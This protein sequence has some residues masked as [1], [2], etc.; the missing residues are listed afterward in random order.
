MGVVYEAVQISLGRRVALKV[1]PFAAT[2]DPKQLQRFRNEAQAAA[3]LQHPHIVPVHYVGCERGVHF[4]AMQFID[5]QT[6]AA[7]IHELRRLDRQEATSP[8]AS[9]GA[10]EPQPTTDYVPVPA[11]PPASRVEPA[12]PPVGALS[13]EHSSRSP[14]FFRT[15]ANLGVQAAEALEHAHQLGVIHRDIKPANLLV[16]TT[17]PLAPSGARGGGEGGRLWVTDFGLAH[18]QSQPGLTLTG[19]LLGTLRFMSPEQAL[20]K[21]VAVDARTD[22]YSLGVTLYELLTLEPAFN[23]RDREEVLRQIAF[24]E[25]RPPRRWNKAIPTELETIVLK[26]MEKNP[27]ERYATA[28]DLAEDLRC[29]LADRPVRARR[30]TLVGRGWR[31]CRRNRALALVSSVAAIAFVAV[32]IGSAFAWQQSLY[33]TSLREA[34]ERTQEALE[35]AEEERGKADNQRVQAE[36]FRRQAESS[37]GTLALERGLTLAE[38]R[39]AGRG[40]LWMAHGL[41]ITPDKAA[42]L[43]RDIRLNLDAW[44]RHIRPLRAFLEDPNGAAEMIFT[45]DGKVLITRS[46]GKTVR[47][48]QVATARPLSEPL[49]KPLGEPLLHEAQVTAMSL[50]PGGKTLATAAEDGRIHL[51]ETATGKIVGVPMKHE[52][53]IMAMVFRPDGKA[54]A[55]A[56][57]DHTARLWDATTGRAIGTPMRHGHRI[58]AAVFSPDGKWLGTA[59]ADKTARLWD[60]SSGK[61][62]GEPLQHPVP[63]TSILF[64]A[65]GTR[66]LTR[67]YR[68]SSARLWDAA[69]GQMIGQP[70]T[71]PDPIVATAFSPDGTIAATASGDG[72]RLWDAA[73]GRAL[74]AFL[75]HFSG[76]LAFSPDGK[77]LASAGGEGVVRLWQVPE[78]KPIGDPLWHRGPVKAMIFSP[79]GQFLATASWDGTARF[80]ETATGKPVGPPLAHQDNVP[81]LAF[82]PNGEILITGGEDGARAWHVGMPVFTLLK[83]TR[84]A[85]ATSRWA[86]MPLHH[87][88]MV[89]EVALSPDRETVATLSGTLQAREARWWE[90]ATGKLV[91]V[92]RH[93]AEIHALAFSPDGKSLATTSEDRNAR[94]WEVATGKLLR[95]LEHPA[96]VWSVAFNPQDGKRLATSAGDR[97]IRL[98]DTVTGNS[99]ILLRDPIRKNGLAFSPDGKMLVMTYDSTVMLY[100]TAEG[101]HLG[102]PLW[103]GDSWALSAAF[104]PDGKT[105]VTGGGDGTARLWKVADLKPFPWKEENLSKN[106]PFASFSHAFR[107]PVYAVAFS[108]D[109]R[110]IVTGG[111][112]GTARLWETATRKPIGTPFR[113]QGWVVSVAVSSDGKTVVTGSLDGT[114]RIWDVPAPVQGGAERIQLWCQVI[115]NMELA[116]DL[117]VQVLNGKTWK[118][119]RKRLEELGG[120]PTSRQEF[121][122]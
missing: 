87:P 75:E 73:S 103:N 110:M 40:L 107:T 89:W 65:D 53:K 108:G 16:E 1:L 23:G 97:I 90:L 44:H 47:R 10:A 95:T 93:D 13:T 98:W 70:L 18:C 84:F 2:L 27:A 3:N 76:D 34:Q 62:R 77:T 114:A 86:D 68:H 17:S 58:L 71:H 29:F 94:V 38:Q 67:G 8:L 26:A 101:K 88:G 4:Y 36:D 85:T 28:A 111:H 41:K 64:N 100:D 42:D 32:A 116:D 60:A 80:L 30:A 66:L 81:A 104:S 113:H 78:G 25:P 22:I 120:P 59:G 21:R 33:A 115:T 117:Q 61:P 72:A 106:Q 102:G 49:V 63:V 35:V 69:T 11:P 109:G 19:D 118:E 74:S 91:R 56:I 54:L 96:P 122:P 50:S 119:R 92:L 45:P 82:S 51:W 9:A 105:L 37:S 46:F 31:W 12:T 20:A 15:V 6:L 48:W 83:G 57:Q 5:G 7:V 112:D 99:R 121:R 79:N 14:T 52:G 39:E 43:E 55:T 24:E